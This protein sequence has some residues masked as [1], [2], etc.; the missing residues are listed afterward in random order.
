MTISIRPDFDALIREEFYSFLM[1]AFGELHAG[2]TYS[3]A[4]HVEALASKLQG[5]RDRQ[6]RR[7]IVNVPPRHLKSLAAS[8][9]LP[10]WLLGHDPTLNIVNVTYAQDLSEKFARDCRLLMTAPWYQA[11]FPT[12]LAS[13]REPLAELTTTK[14]GFRLATSVGGV[15]TGRGADVI[16]IDDPLKPI[17]AHSESRRAAANDWFD[18]TLYSRLNDK[19]K[20][21]I[22]IVMQRL[23]E[24][25][26]TGHVLKQEPWEVA[27]FPAIAED[28]E[29]HQ[30]ETP[31]EPRP[32]QRKAGEA[33]HPARE[34]LAVLERVRAT[35]GEQ[36][37]AAQ[38]QQRPVPAGGGLIKPHWFRRYGE[39]PQKFDR[40]VQ[41][42][43][44]ANTAGDSSDWSV[45]TT[46]GCRG[47]EFYL[48]DVLRKKLA[49]P[50]LKRAVIELDARFAAD[51][52]LVEDR[53]S[54]TQLFQELIAAGC[55]HATR[56]SPQG[57]KVMRMHAESPTIE[58]GFV[59]LPEK[60]PWLADYLAEFLAFPKGRHDDQVDSTAQALA[61]AKR[62]RGGVDGWLEFYRR[63]AG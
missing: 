9:A 25:D 52:I 34:P 46:W 20:G 13:A 28:D 39:R 44:T 8:V 31:G 5:V 58:N 59:L 22:V 45:C 3:P 60:A 17:D 27:A 56:V 55:A 11:L 12:R 18:S 51:V 43:D 40:I 15:L 24:D 54:G 14:G 21:A 47:P 38:Y 32:F 63:M 6:T 19:A 16:V 42:W 1:R 37:F 30:I 33:L 29:A 50:D 7:L 2:Q 62:G 61:W 57:D 53:A 41:S 4:W 35:L 49:Y 26:L 10:A 23:H 48:I 36:N